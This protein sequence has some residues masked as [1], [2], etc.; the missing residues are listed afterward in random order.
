MRCRVRCPQARKEYDDVDE[1]AVS[2]RE[3][4]EHVRHHNVQAILEAMSVIAI[5]LC[6]LHS[7]EHGCVQRACIVVSALMDAL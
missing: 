3:S 5:V 2:T 6:R 1:D 7:L 4:E